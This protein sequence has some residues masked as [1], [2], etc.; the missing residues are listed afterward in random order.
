MPPAGAVAS[1]SSDSGSARPCS[2]KRKR[3][4]VAA[5]RRGGGGDDDGG[6]DGEAPLPTQCSCGWHARLRGDALAMRQWNDDARSDLLHRAATAAATHL[7]GSSNGDARRSI[8]EVGGEGLIALAAAV[9][10][11]GRTRK[12]RDGDVAAGAEHVCIAVLPGGAARLM[13][14]GLRRRN[15]VVGGGCRTASSMDA[16]ITIATE[17]FEAC[18][19]HLPKVGSESG[20]ERGAVA[21]LLSSMRFDAMAA[22]PLLEAMNFWRIKDRF[23]ARGALTKDALVLPARGTL[24]ATLLSCETLWNARA[25]F[26]DAPCGFAHEALRAVLRSEQRVE[27]GEGGGSA[28]GS[29]GSSDPAARLVAAVEGEGRAECCQLSLPLHQ[30]PHTVLSAPT[31]V[32]NLPYAACSV[33][34]ALESGALRAM[35]TTRCAA[36]ALSARAHAVVVDIA[37]DFGDGTL[38]AAGSATG[39]SSCAVRHTL[40]FLPQPVEVRAGEHCAECTVRF[41]VATGGIRISARVVECE[42]K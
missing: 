35:T 8:V 17:A 6:D 13:L 26:P 15:S 23:T 21:A 32:L 22:T 29:S 14:S 4:I 19:V 25:R 39:G 41:D 12:E 10:L 1:S 36:A 27:E 7:L 30:Y 33:A 11:A 5:G 16:A 38:R 31:Q 37:Y 20:G 9:T 28:D 24:V 40:V 34:S 18:S 2:A 42:G 3:A